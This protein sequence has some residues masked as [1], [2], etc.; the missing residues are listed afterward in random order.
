MEVIEKIKKKI[1]TNALLLSNIWSD[2]LELIYES[3]IEILEKFKDGFFIDD[4]MDNKNDINTMDFLNFIRPD[5]RYSDTEL[6]YG[7]SE[8][9][10][11]TPHF[12]AKDQKTVKWED[13]LNWNT[14]KRITKLEPIPESRLDTLEDQTPYKNSNNPRQKMKEELREKGSSSKL[15]NK[16]SSTLTSSSSKNLLWFQR[17]KRILADVD[18][19]IETINKTF[20]YLKSVDNKNILSNDF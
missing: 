19:S 15:D 14:F 10:V 11:A 6:M 5:T 20:E 3:A 18:Q 12:L 9:G 1:P 7:R 16:A 13:L 2:E 4:M 8:S 17:A